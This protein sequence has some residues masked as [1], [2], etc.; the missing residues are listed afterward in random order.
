VRSWRERRTKWRKKAVK[1]ASDTNIKVEA[2]RSKRKCKG[3]IEER[4]LH[5]EEFILFEVEICS[6]CCFQRGM[7]KNMKKPQ[8]CCMLLTDFL[9]RSTKK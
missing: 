4:G 3:K 7:A 2:K 9:L 8:C 6:S 1:A 5:D